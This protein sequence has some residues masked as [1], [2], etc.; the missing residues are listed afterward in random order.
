MAAEMLAVAEI[1]ATD[2]RI[3]EKQLTSV[4]QHMSNQRTP[5]SVCKKTEEGV[6]V[7]VI[8]HVDCIECLRKLAKDAGRYG[9]ERRPRR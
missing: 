4:V 8:D 1:I 3:H 6:I 5:T 9:N 2:L 7:R